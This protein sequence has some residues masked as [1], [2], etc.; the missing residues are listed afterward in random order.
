MYLALNNLQRFICHKTQTTKQY[1]SIVKSQEMDLYYVY[2]IS[3]NRV[4]KPLKKSF[5]VFFKYNK[6][7]FVKYLYWIGI[8]DLLP[9]TQSS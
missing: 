1:F 4:Q 3:Y 2:L 6:D 8:L 7:L 5:F 9:C